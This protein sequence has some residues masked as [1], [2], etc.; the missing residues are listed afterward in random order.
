MLLVAAR[1][2]LPVG[3]RSEFACK[4]RVRG[5]MTQSKSLTFLPPHPAL[6]ATFSPMGRREWR[7]HWQFFPYAI[8]LPLSPSYSV[9][10]ITSQKM[11]GLNR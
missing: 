5:K 11:P 6:R 2:P 8:V 4:F 3:E 7:L 1:S 9:S 10:L